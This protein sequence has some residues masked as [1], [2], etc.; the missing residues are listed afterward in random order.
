MFNDVH[1]NK[2]RQTIF[3][4]NLFKRKSITFFLITSVYIRHTNQRFKIK[5]LKILFFKVNIQKSTPKYL[6]NH[7]NWKNIVKNK[8]L[9]VL[10]FY[11]I[12]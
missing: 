6:F 10:T 4:Q 12:N 7:T 2:Q 8:K 3:Y 11:Y 1:S 9:D 5:Q